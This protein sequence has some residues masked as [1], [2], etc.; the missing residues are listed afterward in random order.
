MSRFRPTRREFLGKMALVAGGA[1]LLNPAPVSAQAG[2]LVR[3]NVASLAPNGPEIQQLREAFRIIR[4]RSAVNWMDRRGWWLQANIHA[5]SCSHANW[6][7]L[8]WHRAYI[9]YFERILRQ[10]VGSATL[11]LPYW[12]WS[13]PATRRLPAPFWGANNPLNMSTR[14]IGP[15]DQA[16]AEFVDRTRIIEP[17]L[18]TR[19]F[20]TFGGF[21]SGAPTQRVAGG[22]LEGTPHNNIHNWVGGANG[23]MSFPVSAARD[24]IFWLHHA[25]V[26]R[27]WAEWSR[28]NPGRQPTDSR[29]LN[30]RFSFYD[31]A[32]RLVTVATSGLLT[33][34][35]LG[36]R[37][38]TQT[39]AAPLTLAAAPGVQRV[40]A[41]PAAPSTLGP[42]PVTVP[43]QPPPAMRQPL[44]R[45]VQAAPG[46]ESL[47]LAIEGI[48][49]PANPQ[50]L[51]RVFINLPNADAKTSFE[52]IHYAG[53]FSFFTG[54]DRGHNHHSGP[55][56]QLIDVTETVR[57]LREAGQFKE[58]EPL[59]VTLVTSPIDPKK[60][61][62]AR[63]P[64]KKVSLSVVR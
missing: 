24:P 35:A 16:P 40:E 30:Q 33:T 21:A 48:E 27:L 53:N 34:T 15:N 17:I 50:V 51:V 44:N 8:P 9:Y 43:L 3:R 18:N 58:G 23:E 39:T 60:E 25:N 14:G 5:A 38:D 22:S 63:I 54:E 49:P 26:D 46:G 12:D 36:Y 4:Q 19:S 42:Q 62:G 52:D 7:F 47:Q 41:V 29:W 1:V 2:L 55:L 45:A 57:R 20:S 31:E 59:N 13:D 64:F 56:T 11:T 61:A 10:A 6:W 37:Y 28:R 32:A